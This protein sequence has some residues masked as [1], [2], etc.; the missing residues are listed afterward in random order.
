MNSKV[1]IPG[2][3]IAT[4]SHGR[5]AN[6]TF[7]PHA[8]NAGYFGPGIEAEDGDD[9]SADQFFDLVSEALMVSYDK[10]SAHFTC[11]WES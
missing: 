4:I 10:K 5:M 2:R 6:F 7:V 1:E 3:M 8:A 9:V 11:E